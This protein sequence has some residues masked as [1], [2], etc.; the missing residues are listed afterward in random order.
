MACVGDNV[1]GSVVYVGV[2]CVLDGVGVCGREGACVCVCVCVCECV[3][4]CVCV[5]ERGVCV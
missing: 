4:V 1:C 5:C 2:V 3:C